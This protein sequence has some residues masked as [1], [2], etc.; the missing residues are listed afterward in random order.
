M[1]SWRFNLSGFLRPRACLFHF[2]RTAREWKERAVGEIKFLKDK[3][4]NKVRLLM[5][6]DRTKAI[7]ADHISELLVRMTFT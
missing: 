5:R 3:Q 7:C 4:T 6:Q 2:D 1:K